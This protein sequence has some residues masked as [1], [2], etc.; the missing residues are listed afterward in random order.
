MS[1]AFSWSFTTASN[2]GGDTTAPFVRSFSPSNNSVGTNVSVAVTVTFSEAMSESTINSSNFTLKNGNTAVS[3]TISYDNS[4][5]TAS[6]SPNAN[7]DYGTSYTATVTSDMTD[8]AGNK[9]QIDTIWSFTTGAPPQGVV[10]IGGQTSVPA[11]GTADVKIDIG[12]VTNFVAYQIDLTFD[13]S[14][15]QITDDQR[16]VSSG[17]IGTKTVP[18]DGWSFVAQNK[19]RLIGHIQSGSATGQG[20]LAQI[21]FNVIG[22][23]GHSSSLTFSSPSS[24]FGILGTDVIILNCTFQ[25]GSVT[26]Q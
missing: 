24:I 17:L 9:L 15:L 23:T 7:L 6:F 19:I 5:M 16:N 12:Q 10:S 22:T 20:Y 3:G 2:G 25:N 1:A 21:H 14:V 8:L 18:A 13:D 26:I 4:N 11:G